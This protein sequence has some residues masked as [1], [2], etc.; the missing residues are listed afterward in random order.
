MILTPQNRA[1]SPPFLFRNPVVTFLRASEMSHAVYALLV[2]Y[3]HWLHWLLVLDFHGS[4]V[5]KTRNSCAKPLVPFI[6]H[7]CKKHPSLHRCH[8]CK[9]PTSSS[10]QAQLLVFFGCFWLTG[11]PRTT[12]SQR[13]RSSQDFWIQ[14]TC[15]LSHSDTTSG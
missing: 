15:S 12:T 11:K 4:S 8:R 10:S 3:L 5:C 13:P 1:M 14:T 6:R 9:S 7:M 2:V